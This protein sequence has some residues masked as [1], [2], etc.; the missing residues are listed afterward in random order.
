[1]NFIVT[2]PQTNIA[3]AIQLDSEFGNK[4]GR[5]VIMGGAFPK[6]GNATKNSEF[7]V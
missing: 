7:N 2:G 5:L 1:L 4:I 6:S 3:Q